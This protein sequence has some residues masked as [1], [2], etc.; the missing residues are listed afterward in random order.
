MSSVAGTVIGRI[1]AGVL[2]LGLL[3]G[4]GFGIY[5]SIKGRPP[6]MEEEVF[7]EETPLPVDP[8]ETPIP[9][10]AVE[11]DA[12][13]IFGRTYYQGLRLTVDQSYQSGEAVRVRYENDARSFEAAALNASLETS[14][15][16]FSA[17]TQN[18]T[19]APLANGTVELRFPDA[20]GEP[21]SLTLNNLEPLAADGFADA[22]GAP[23]VIPL[24]GAE[25]PATT[26]ELHIAGEDSYLGLTASVDQTYTE[27]GMGKIVVQMNNGENRILFSDSTLTLTTDSGAYTLIASASFEAN[28]ATALTLY[29]DNAE[30]TPER[31]LIPSL[32]A[33][34]AAGVSLSDADGQIEIDFTGTGE[35]QAPVAYAP[36]ATPAATTDQTAE[37]TA[38]PTAVPIYGWSDWS[39]EE[40]PAGVVSESKTQYRYRYVS[41]NK[42]VTEEKQNFPASLLTSTTMDMQNYLGYSDYS[43]VS[44][45]E[46][47]ASGE[48]YRTVNT[49]DA[50]IAYEAQSDDF[51]IY[52]Y[53]YDAGNN[54]Y[55]VYLHK[56]MVTTVYYC[57]TAYSEWTDEAA[58]VEPDSRTVGERVETVSRTLWRYYQ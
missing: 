12:I 49:E 57:F 54:V 37:P 13:R 1:V 51:Q 42:S 14:E 20:T 29:F 22:S 2:S 35:T 10:V 17:E 41:G 24:D 48:Y 55:K 47:T 31:L 5:K 39:E 40:P 27:N 30:G 44:Q 26:E 15:G 52:S 19:V 53:E 4:V 33:L 50:A 18:V 56:I 34:D 9:A 6:R 28:T 38:E 43:I 8:E 32:T 46:Y 16:T 21:K 7:A 58:F 11:S 25:P 3:A 45:T 23:I 36:A